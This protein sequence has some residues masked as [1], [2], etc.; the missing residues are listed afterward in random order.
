MTLFNY[1]SVYLLSRT[2]SYFSANA[3]NSSVQTVSLR[4]PFS[5]S[6]RWPPFKLTMAC[7]Q[8]HCPLSAGGYCVRMVGFSFHV[9]N[10]LTLLHL[11]VGDPL[12]NEYLASSIYL[13][14]SARVLH[15]PAS[16]STVRA[17][18]MSIFEML[19]Q[20]RCMSSRPPD[21]EVSLTQN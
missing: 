19:L 16:S 18:A 6:S 21:P 15:R 17:T 12:S 5:W 20:A 14:I 3:V 8:T 9:H 1:T 11:T 4:R 7:S 10:Y 13:E 2:N